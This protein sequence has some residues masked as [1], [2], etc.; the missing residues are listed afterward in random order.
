MKFSLLLLSLLLAA[1][2]VSGQVNSQCPTITV[3]GPDGIVDPG[4]V[5][6]FKVTVKP[7]ESK[8]TFNWT[9]SRG[10]IAEGQGT[11]TIKV[12]VGQD[13]PDVTAT[14]KIGGLPQ[15]CVNVA[16]ETVTDLL[17]GEPIRVRV[18]TFSLP[19]STISDRR[20]QIVGEAITDNPTSQFFV[21][22]PT[23]NSIR[24]TLI[25]RL[26]K[27]V[28]KVIDRSHITFVETDGKNKII[29]IWLVPPGATPPTCEEC[30][31]SRK[32]STA[33]DCPI[34][35]VRGPTEVAHPSDLI[36]FRLDSTT[37]SQNVQLFWTVSAGTIESGQ[38]SREIKVR[39]PSETSAEMIKAVLN[40]SGLS[41]ECLNTAEGIAAVKIIPIAD[42]L[43]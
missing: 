20:F 16:S 15:E 6:P 3:F 14:V 12:R 42:P 9:V 18:D 5:V 27:S 38:W 28:H 30:E 39:V 23:D 24:E 36:S 35:T 21:F 11:P 43:F 40:V 37:L 26:E 2:S 19:L 41:K 29:E 4:D 17:G 1:L 33:Q 32:D 8:L 22:V 34:L 31:I 7:T 10:T 13:D 25:S